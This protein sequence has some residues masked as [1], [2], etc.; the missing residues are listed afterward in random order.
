MTNAYDQFTIKKSRA[1]EPIFHVA[2]A[3]LYECQHF[4]FSIMNYLFCLSRLGLPTLQIEEVLDILNDK[5][6]LTAGQLLKE[7]KRH[8]KMS[9]QIPVIFSEALDARN[10]IIHHQLIRNVH[11]FSSVK[12]RSDVVQ[13]IRFLTAK[14]NLANSSLAPFIEKVSADLDG[15]RY[16]E[17]LAEFKKNFE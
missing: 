3:A 1:V 10:R 12:G 17:M 5:K 16:Q 9:G 15:N 11:K 14:V 7:L 2:G 4:E 8:V 6:K 13:E